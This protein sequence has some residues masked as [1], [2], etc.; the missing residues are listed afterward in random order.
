MTHSR[1]LYVA[2]L[3]GT[4]YVRDTADTGVVQRIGVVSR[5]FCRDNIGGGI[6][7][8]LDA[9]PNIRKGDFLKTNSGARST[10]R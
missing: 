1:K 8:N 4:R 3:A 10:F 2:G 9:H 6:P 7:K 5:K